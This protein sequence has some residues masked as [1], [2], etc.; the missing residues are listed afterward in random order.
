MKTICEKIFCSF[1]S[2]SYTRKLDMKILNQEREQEIKS[3]L[4]LPH[5]Q[6]PLHKKDTL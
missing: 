1:L 3:Q 4:K 5:H 6:Q 2:S